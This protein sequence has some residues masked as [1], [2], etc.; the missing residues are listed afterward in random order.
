MTGW[1]A[2]ALACRPG[3]QIST[4]KLQRHKGEQLT[5]TSN[6]L[7]TSQHLSG[8]LKQR[9]AA[10]EATAHSLSICRPGKLG[11][12]GKLVPSYTASAA[13]ASGGSSCPRSGQH[14]TCCRVR[15]WFFS[16][17]G[18]LMLRHTRAQCRSL[19]LACSS[20]GAVKKLGAAD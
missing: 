9:A 4:C 16:G 14:L 19:C 20:R 13:V 1:Q 7:T 18:I 8:D 5:T 3:R 10:G 15:N 12:A 2:S 11:T 6:M 17:C